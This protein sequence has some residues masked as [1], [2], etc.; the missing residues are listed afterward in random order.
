MI[1]RVIG[2]QEWAPHMSERSRLQRFLHFV[3]R[4]ISCFFR[5]A[6]FFVH[7]LARLAAAFDRNNFSPQ[8]FRNCHNK[9]LCTWDQSAADR[10][11]RW[12]I[13]CPYKFADIQIKCSVRSWVRTLF[14]AWT[15]NVKTWK[16]SKCTYS[17]TLQKTDGKQKILMRLKRSKCRC[18]WD[19]RDGEI[20]GK[21]WGFVG[22]SRKSEKYRENRQNHQEF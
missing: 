3:F 4:S 2:W 20:T 14:Q 17:K 6:H 22:E 18:E 7:T 21:L 19:F 9:H 12:K 15:D 5:L 16:V 10:L 1:K 13:S 8:S 11:Y